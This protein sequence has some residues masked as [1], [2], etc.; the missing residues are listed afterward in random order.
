MIGLY[1]VQI[2]LYVSVFVKRFVEYGVFKRQR[3][4]EWRN[5]GDTISLIISLHGLFRMGFFA[6]ARMASTLS[7]DDGDAIILLTRINIYLDILGWIAGSVGASILVQSIV[8]THSS[9]SLF[10]ALK[11]RSS[12]IDISKLYR[13]YRL[14]YLV[15]L[16]VF[17]SMTAFVGL[18]GTLEQYILWRKVTYGSIVFTCLCVSA[19]VLGYFGESVITKMKV[20]SA[21]QS[22]DPSFVSFAQSKGL[23]LEEPVRPSRKINTTQLQIQSLRAQ[24]WSLI[25]IVYIGS[26]IVTTSFIVGLEY[27]QDEQSLLFLKMVTD[28]F[29]FV[30]SA[31]YSFFLFYAEWIKYIKQ[32][33]QE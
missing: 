19:P 6:N 31:F 7:K 15:S 29:A 10:E 18:N 8:L 11:T 27:D 17:T 30:L 3:F 1:F 4:S 13:A 32:K 2:L 26:A 5:M 24:I 22:K 23:A 28:G 16:I 12:G 9:L 20:G 25:I 14:V 21:P 33:Y